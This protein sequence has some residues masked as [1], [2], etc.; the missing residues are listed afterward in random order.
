MAAKLLEEEEEQNEK[1]ADD[2]DAQ[3]E[4][5]PKKSSKKKKG[6]TTEVLK[7]PR[8]GDMFGNKVLQSLVYLCPKICVLLYLFLTVM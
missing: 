8:F 7:D 1:D 3:K 5:A 6:L 2:V 4:P